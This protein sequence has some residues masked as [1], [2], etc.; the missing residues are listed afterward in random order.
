MVT[1]TR[2]PLGELSLIC[3]LVVGF[4]SVAS[5]TQAQ[6]AQPYPHQ[7]DPSNWTG[8]LSA[9]IGKKTLRT[10][11]IPGSHDSGTAGISPLSEIDHL[12]L[13][14]SEI[15]IPPGP[16]G[17]ENAFISNWSRAQ[18]LSLTEQLII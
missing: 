15:H 18:G 12:D 11:V 6:E 9:H 7:V 3:V 16:P 8:V 1:P 14:N 2:S 10:L 17:V 5:L 4:V 13:G